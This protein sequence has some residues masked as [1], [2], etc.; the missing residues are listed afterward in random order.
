MEKKRLRSLIVNNFIKFNNK[1]KAFQ[2][3]SLGRYT[4][5]LKKNYYARHDEHKIQD[6]FYFWFLERRQGKSVWKRHTSI[7][8]SPG[9]VVVHTLGIII[10]KVILLLFLNTHTYTHK[11]NPIN[12]QINECADLLLKVY[13]IWPTDDKR[14][15]HTHTHTPP[16]FLW[17]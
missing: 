7:F 14:I 10:R 11:H 5:V 8:K 17:Q 6:C 16:E 13:T 12:S 1:K 2:N 4:Q 9:D 3:I 15:T